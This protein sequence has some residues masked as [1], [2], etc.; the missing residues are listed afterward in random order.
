[1]RPK[2]A[3]K[4]FSSASVERVILDITN[5][6]KDKDLARFLY[7]VAILMCIFSYSLSRLFE[8]T[9]PNTLDTTIKWYNDDL[10]FVVTGDID[11]EW[12]RDSS[13]QFRVYL[14]LVS[15]DE[16][17]RNLTRGVIN[18]QG[19]LVTCLSS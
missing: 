1:M 4:T 17:L 11:A 8:N 18:L 14:P 6:M 3:C 12:L 16:E 13:N 5:K 19:G 10:T 9:F 7:G 15:I 2:E